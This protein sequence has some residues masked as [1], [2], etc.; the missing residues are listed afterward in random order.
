MPLPQTVG[1]YEVEWIMVA[2]ALQERG[3]MLLPLGD[4][5][6]AFRLRQRFYGFR[7]AFA[8]H[9]AANP[10]I[11]V[12][13]ETAAT[14][15]ANGDLRLQRSPLSTLLRGILEKT[16][17][18]VSMPATEEEPAMPKH[19]QAILEYLAGQVAGRDKAGD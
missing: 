17:V 2:Q 6:L 15:D 11:S 3:E 8:K 5:K 18:T 16:K 1:Q 14:V 4:A 19:E 10:Y 9:D 12:L 7:K 13:M